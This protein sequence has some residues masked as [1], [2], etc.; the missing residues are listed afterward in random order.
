MYPEGFATTVS[1][2]G[3]SEGLCGAFRPGHF[4]GVATV[5]TKLFLQTGADLAFFNEKGI[6]QLHVVRRFTRDLARISH[7]I[8]VHRGSESGK[9]LLRLTR[10][11]GVPRCKQSVARN[12]LVLEL[13]KSA[14]W[15]PALTAGRSLRM[16]ARFCW[17]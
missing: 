9:M 4:D 8:E 6:Q 2:S 12:G 3:V 16:P 13:L 5:V 7:E 10:G 14:P 15:W 17:G 1:V 11:R